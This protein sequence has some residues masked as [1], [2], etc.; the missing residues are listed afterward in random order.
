[1]NNLAKVLIALLCAAGAVAAIVYVSQR[2][3]GPTLEQ[4]AEA[5]R[6]AQREQ[7]REICRLARQR[8]SVAGAAGKDAEEEREQNEAVVRVKCAPSGL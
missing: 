6:D 7:S 8:L 5:E 1:M 4:A 2:P 3:F